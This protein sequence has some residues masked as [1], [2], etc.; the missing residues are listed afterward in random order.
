MIT[1]LFA[2][3]KALERAFTTLRSEG[4]SS[5]ITRDLMSFEDFTTIVGLEE[6]YQED[7]RYKIESECRAWRSQNTN[8]A[9]IDAR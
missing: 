9:G 6:R 7:G 5:S 8:G 4:G 2:A 3:A 1:G